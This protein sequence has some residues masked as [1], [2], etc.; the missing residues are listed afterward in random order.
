MWKHPPATTS[1]N[2]AQEIVES[3]RLDPPLLGRKRTRHAVPDLQ[4]SREPDNYLQ[5][6]RSAAHDL[7]QP[8]IV[9]QA[10]TEL[11]ANGANS[12]LSEEQQAILTEI[13][14]ATELT[15]HLLD[16]TLDLANAD[17][18]SPLLRARPLPLS[19][20]IARCVAL[21]AP[22]AERKEMRLSFVPDR[23]R[24]TVLIDPTEMVKV[25][26]NLIGNAIKYC[27]PG[28]SIA[29]RVLSAKRK[30]VASIQDDG[31]GIT[32]A[33]MMTLFTPFQ[34][35]RAR[36]V[37]EEHSSGLGLAISKRIVE[38]HGGQILVESTVG[39][40]ST[41]YVSLPTHTPDT[42]PRRTQNSEPLAWPAHP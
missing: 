24:Q 39:N 20:V 36:A 10:Y 11:L 21:N 19:D 27:Q 9:I 6:L 29:I 33:D 31:P 18:Q 34:R 37:S 38:Q 15:M 8:L 1:Q 23:G 14:S 28:A 40:G 16:E 32:P 5:L 12:A 35:T 41:F 22:L 7:R 26:N 13:L 4:T 17:S 2:Q 30:V 3:I 25:F 42:L